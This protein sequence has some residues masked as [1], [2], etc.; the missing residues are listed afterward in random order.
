MSGT[1]VNSISRTHLFTTASSVS[2]MSKYISLLLYRIP[3]FRHGMGL[4]NALILLVDGPESPDT[5]VT[6]RIL[7]MSEGGR[8][9]SRR[10]FGEVVS[11]CP[12]ASSVS[13]RSWWTTS[14]LSL[15][16]GAVTSP[17]YSTRM[18]KKVRMNA[19]AYSGSTFIV[20]AYM[21]SMSVYTLNTAAEQL[22]ISRDGA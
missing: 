14:K 9:M 19:K 21:K 6:E 11:G 20:A 4:E 2:T 7:V 5:P 18:S 1:G 10:A 15:R 22:T 12:P 17:K 16:V 8:T 3:A 13:S